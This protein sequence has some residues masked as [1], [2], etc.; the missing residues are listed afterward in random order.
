MDDA[1]QDICPKDMGEHDW[2]PHV[3]ADG[4][5]VYHCPKCGVSTGNRSLRGFNGRNTLRDAYE[6][7]LDLAVYLRQLVY[8]V[9]TAEQARINERCAII[10][11]LRKA[12]HEWTDG[13]A[14]HAAAAHWCI[15]IIE[16]RHAQP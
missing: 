1:M 14:I 13:S 12:V 15:N 8:E 10:T 3:R 16:K 11:E 5:D 7:V 6:E 2:Q 9:E 4:K